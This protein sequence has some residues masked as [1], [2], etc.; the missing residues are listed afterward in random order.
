MA[1][2]TKIVFLGTNG[3]YDTKIGDTIS[4]LI[5]TPS[6]YIILDA[7]NGFYKVDQYIKKN[8]PVYLFISHFHLD[9]IFGLHIL[10]KF[11]FPQG[12]TLCCYKGGKKILKQLLRQ[13]FTIPYSKLPFKLRFRELKVGKN[14]GFPFTLTCNQMVH[15]TKC[16]GFRFEFTDQVVSYCPDTGANDA[17]IFLSQNADLMIT[18]CAWKPGQQKGVWP[19]LSPE[20][21]ARLAKKASAKQLVLVHFDADNYRTVTDR[22]NA[23]RVARKIFPHSLAAKDDMVLKL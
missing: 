2:Q 8:K 19:H 18:E 14:N 17:L 11:N 6:A 15:S 22:S 12:L 10:N 20:K 1:N 23:Q 13:P 21:A 4:V 7:G 16:F 5:D 3:W 9:H